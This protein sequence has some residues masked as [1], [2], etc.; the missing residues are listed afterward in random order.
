MNCPRCNSTNNSV[1][2]T[3]KAKGKVQR[4]RWCNGCN[5]IFYTVELNREELRGL[6][7]FPDQVREA[8]KGVTALQELVDATNKLK[9][10][11]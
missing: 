5:N 4:A 3:R 11:E 8:L 7:G 6:Q 10:K 9:L 2:D 1:N